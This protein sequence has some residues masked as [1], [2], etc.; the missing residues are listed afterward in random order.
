MVMEKANS[1]KLKK[2][3][4]G[5]IKASNDEEPVVSK[6]KRRP[7]SD[8][9]VYTVEI[10]PVVCKGC[11]YCQEMCPKGVFATSDTFNASG[12]KPT[13]VINPDRCV[14]CLKCLYI[15]PDFAITIR[16]QRNSKR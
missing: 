6:E 4:F 10:N 15:C 16:S 3:G 5:S 14:G 2:D 11:G 9:R 12:Y 13:A 1:L 8:I 7:V